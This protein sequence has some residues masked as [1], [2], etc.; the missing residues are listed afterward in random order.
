MTLALM[1]EVSRM[2]AAFTFKCSKLLECRNA[3]PLATSRA[4]CRPL[5]CSPVSSSPGECLRIIGI[6]AGSA[7]G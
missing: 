2:L 7:E 3:K 1:S 6:V 5:Q 4:T